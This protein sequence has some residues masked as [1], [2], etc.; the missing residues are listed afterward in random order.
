VKDKKKTMITL[1]DPASESEE[2]LFG[3]VSKRKKMDDGEEV[4]VARTD[5]QV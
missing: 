5:K 3:P 4:I 2:E 1:H